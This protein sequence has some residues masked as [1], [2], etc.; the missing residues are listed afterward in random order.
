MAAKKQVKETGI[1]SDDIIEIGDYNG[2]FIYAHNNKTKNAYKLHNH[3]AKTLDYIYRHGNSFESEIISETGINRITVRKAVKL[4]SDL[5]IILQ[6][7]K[8]SKS[9]QPAKTFTFNKDLFH[10]H[11]GEAI[12]M[13]GGFYKL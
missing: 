5:K 9:N 2:Y 8:R 1:K 13:F 10:L 6:E 11:S 3:Y 7:M 12:I 4:L